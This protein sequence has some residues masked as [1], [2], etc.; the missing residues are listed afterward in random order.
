M[1]QYEPMLRLKIKRIEKGMTQQELADLVGI[2]QN[3]LSYYETGANFPRKKILDKLA[4][5]L[6]CEVKDIV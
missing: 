6:D 4:A 5:A 3:L 2:R 1:K